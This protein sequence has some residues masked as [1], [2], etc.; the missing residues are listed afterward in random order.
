MIAMPLFQIELNS[1]LVPISFAADVVGMHPALIQ[2]MVRNG[3]VRGSAPHRVRG[4]VGNVS[5]DDLRQ[6]QE[7][8]LAAKRTAPDQ[9]LP[10]R[11][12]A[13][14][15]QFNSTVIYRWIRKGWIRRTQDGI[16]ESELA[17]ARALADLTGFGRGKR[18]F[19]ST[20][21]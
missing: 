7:L 9:V 13:E 8:L 16:H 3:V 12:A 4:I 17:Y 14:K 21:A 19:P 11:A 6:L 5:L 15:Y 10:I 2:Q 20:P 18:V 1:D